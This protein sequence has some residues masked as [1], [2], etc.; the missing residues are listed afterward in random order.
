MIQ[1]DCKPVTVKRQTNT[2]E[3]HLIIIAMISSNKM[4]FNQSKSK[5]MKIFRP[6]PA[7]LSLLLTILIVAGCE[8]EEFTFKPETPV[9][10]LNRVM[11]RRERIDIPAPAGNSYFT[12][13]ELR[14]LDAKRIQD[15]DEIHHAKSYSAISDG[16][17]VYDK[18]I[19]L[20]Q[21]FTGL[22]VLDNSYLKVQIVSGG[23]TFNPAFHFDAKV[24]GGALQNA[25]A[26]IKN[27]CTGNAAYKV[28]LKRGYQ[29]TFSKNLYSWDQSFFTLIGGVIPFWITFNSQMDANV[30]VKASASCWIQQGVTV[31]GNIT[32]GAKW[33][34]TT[35]WT[36]VSSASSPLFSATK[37]AFNSNVNLTV[38]PGLKVY[39]SANLYSVLGPQL[40][41]NPYFNFYLNAGSGGYYIDRKAYLRGNV[42]FSL[43]G[44]GYSTTFFN[45]DV[46]NVS[47]TFTRYY[48]R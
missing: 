4:K 10:E 15:E 45:R 2:K 40:C 1:S 16:A 17:Y 23:I 43:K 12:D 21:N 19:N 31:S 20:S 42:Y 24:S 48:Y 13:D 27:S 36:N 6:K 22:T 34:R 39:V 5:T 25:Q 47:K 28:T 9:A 7:V 18:G 30:S 3:F 41:V 38:T 26:Y 44:L 14:L 37:P 8:R 32:L 35:G 46:F 33:S 11:D 29:N